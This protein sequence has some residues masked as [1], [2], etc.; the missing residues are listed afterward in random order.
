MTLPL[1][2]STAVQTWETGEKVYSFNI[3]RKKYCPGPYKTNRALCYCSIALVRTQRSW[4]QDSPSYQ[5]PSCHYQESGYCYGTDPRSATTELQITA[6]HC[7]QTPVNNKNKNCNFF[8]WFRWRSNA[9]VFKLGFPGN[10]LVQDPS[11]LCRGKS[12]SR[13]FFLRLG[14]PSTKICLT[15]KNEALPKRFLNRRILKTPALVTKSIL[16]TTLFVNDD[17]TTITWFSCHKSQTECPVIV[18]FQYKFLGRTVW[19]GSLS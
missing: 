3:G 18:A 10:G 1:I 19:N 11:N 4:S 2:H 5:T 13:A 7:H 16:K 9:P 8:Y 15:H 12:Q 14:L 6:D 17:V